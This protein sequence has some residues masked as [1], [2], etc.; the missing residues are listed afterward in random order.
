MQWKAKLPAGKTY[1]RA[2]SSLDL[3]PT[4]RALATPALPE[5]MGAVSIPAQEWPLKPGPREIAVTIR[6]PHTGAKIQGVL[7]AT[8]LMLSLH[9]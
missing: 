7:Q 1:D 9:N 2:V 3:L 8:G 4:A 5:T 6:Y